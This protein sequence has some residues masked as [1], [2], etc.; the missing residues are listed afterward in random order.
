MEYYL[1]QNKEKND[2]TNINFED[3]MDIDWYASNYI[4]IINDKSLL[5]NKLG[6]I[7]D[8]IVI[9]LQ[10]VVGTDN[11]DSLL[12]K[13]ESNMLKVIKVNTI[14]KYNDKPSKIF[15]SMEKIINRFVCKKFMN[16]KYYVTVD[17]DKIVFYLIDKPI[18]GVKM[19]H[20]IE[21]SRDMMILGIEKEAKTMKEL[22]TI[23]LLENQISL[24]INPTE[25]Q[26]KQDI[27]I[28]IYNDEIVCDISRITNEY[29]KNVNEVIKCTGKIRYTLLKSIIY[30]IIKICDEKNDEINKKKRSD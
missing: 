10:N 13:M 1:W 4:D 21:I 8:S 17:K 22:N 7:L 14:K 2:I 29:Q 28:T 12:K 27:F 18:K 20:V 23:F 26:N 16:E 6:E 9:E 15:N 25:N 19:K 11:Y 3:Y 24:R 5:V 30:C